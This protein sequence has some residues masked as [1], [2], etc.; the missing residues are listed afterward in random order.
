M[1]V[2]PDAVGVGFDPL[3]DL[4]V[5]QVDKP[6]HL[7]AINLRT[8]TPYQRALLTIDGTVTTFAV[9]KANAINAALAHIAH[10]RYP[11]HLYRGDLTGE[12]I[13]QAE[14]AD[15][16]IVCISCVCGHEDLVV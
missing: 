6:A 9:V 8:L 13:N 7:K 5:A 3:S 1:T 15:L 14:L 16:Q 10:Y 4:L 2:H 11:T 12:A